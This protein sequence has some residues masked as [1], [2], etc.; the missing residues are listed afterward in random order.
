MKKALR[1]FRLLPIVLVG[2]GALLVLKVAGLTFEGGYTLSQ[3]L[4]RGET[5]TVTTVPASN[6]IQ[7]RSET[8]PL[9]VAAA[10]PPGARPWAQQM[11]YPDVTGSVAAAK[12]PEKPP[13][14]PA[15]KPPETKPAAPPPAAEPPQP[16]VS[17]AE[18]AL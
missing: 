10:R 1:E 5:M 12:P 18:R 14:P 6:A 7:M 2:V 4:T 8:V 9:E 15:A 17:A 16:Q 3:R 13:E 11:L